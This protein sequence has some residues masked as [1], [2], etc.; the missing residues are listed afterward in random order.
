MIPKVIHYCWLSG[1]AYPQKIE[2][3]IATWHKICI[4]GLAKVS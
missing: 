1:E 3:C 4:M 2:Y